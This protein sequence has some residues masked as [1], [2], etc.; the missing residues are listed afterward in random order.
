MT[1]TKDVGR[2]TYE[3]VADPAGTTYLLHAVPSGH[4][5]FSVYMAQGPLEFLI[6]T[7]GTKI[8]NRLVFRG[9]WTLLAWRSDVYA[10]SGSGCTRNGSPRRRRRWRRSTGWRSRS[11]GTAG[12]DAVVVAALLGLGALVVLLKTIEH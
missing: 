2:G 4:L 9:G 1:T 8:V 11:A 10:P 6:Q 7:C 12:R 5:G 3:R